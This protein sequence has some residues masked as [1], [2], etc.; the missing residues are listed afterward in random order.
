MTD[1]SID[2]T[3]SY[4]QKSG[5]KMLAFLCVFLI[6]GSV[7]IIKFDSYFT[8]L[9]KIRKCNAEGYARGD[10][11]TACGAVGIHRYSFGSI[12]L[13]SQKN[14]VKNAQNADVIIFGNSRT[15]RSFS[16]DA[17]DNYFKTKGL[18]YMV[19]ASEGASYRSAV[20]MVDKMNLSPKIVMVNNEIFASD[21]ISAG[22][23]EL[24][25]FPDKYKTRFD[26][27]NMAQTLQ[28]N[29]CVSKFRWLKN[30]YCSGKTR[31]NWRSA[32]TGRL[33]W[34]L[35]AA[36]EKQEKIVAPLEDTGERNVPRFLPNAEEL[37]GHSDFKDSC[38]VL[39]IVNSPASSADT[40]KGI[41]GALDIQTVY[42]P[43]DDLYTYDKSHLDRPNSEKWA[44]AFVKELD[45]AIDKCLKGEGRPDFSK[46]AKYMD[47]YHKQRAREKEAIEKR[48]EERKIFRK[49]AEQA[50]IDKLEARKTLRDA[51]EQKRLEKL[52]ARKNARKEAE[53]K[54]KDTLEARRIAREE[55]DRKRLEKIKARTA[56]KGIAYN[57]ESSDI[58]GK[59]DF[60]KWTISDSAL[61]SDESVRAPNGKTDAD[62][63]SIVK[64]AGN[65]IK[66]ANRKRPIKA[67]NTLTFGGWFWSE[68]E[69]ALI[70]LQ[71][72]RSC[73]S[74]TP[75][76]VTTLTSRLSPEPHRMEISHVFKHNH[77]CAV[78]KI[79]GIKAD[80]KINMWRGRTKFRKR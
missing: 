59:T 66:Y 35:V 79:S 23:R 74:D 37:I 34:D 67:G 19:L 78:V 16:T 20:L 62:Q 69:G 36:P 8:D 61:I 5:W 40:L 71:I 7:S 44:E 63:M 13:G 38:P 26:F 41:G 24:V 2:N 28:R 30:Y 55:A 14:A 72:V 27:F 70:R 45:P 60:E 75:L 57:K 32:T 18:T 53:Q 1:V 58:A 10:F 31:S 73:S 52:E 42:T 50:R 80:T 21:K 15:M 11:M 65:I 47:D 39:Y 29:A 12:Y 9:W 3:V 54:V 43:V 51:A 77:D 46:S 25:D 33:K 76:E 6:A 48:L 17:I 64:T 68:D 49:E 56:V 4:T 22:F